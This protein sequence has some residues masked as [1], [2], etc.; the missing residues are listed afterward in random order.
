MCTGGYKIRLFPGHVLEGEKHNPNVWPCSAPSKERCPGWNAKTSTNTH[1]DAAGRSVGC[2][3][4]YAGPKCSM[5]KTPGFYQALDKS[6]NPCPTDS[7]LQFLRSA[8]P[9]ICTLVS[10]LA[11]TLLIVWRMETHQKLDAGT[12]F[13]RAL[14]HTKDFCVWLVLSAQVP[15]LLSEN[16][17]SRFTSF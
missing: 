1:H 2:G 13:R 12:P 6:C 16:S 3:E 8:A 15:G 4:A 9:F 5:C 17:S 11:F 10:V 14:G 7:F